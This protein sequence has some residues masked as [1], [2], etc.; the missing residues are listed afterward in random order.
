METIHVTF[1]EL[2][3]QVAPVHISA[4]P[5]SKLLSPEPISS[6]LVQHPTPA[7]PYVTT[8][9][10]ILKILFEPMIVEYFETPT[11]DT[12]TPPAAVAAPVLYNSNDPSVST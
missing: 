7:V 10:E 4:G 11:D 1:I 9:N 3:E 12:P 8:T 2:T 6:G 5:A